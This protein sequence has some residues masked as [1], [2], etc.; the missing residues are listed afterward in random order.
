MD[1][2]LVYQKFSKTEESLH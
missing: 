2:D 1:I